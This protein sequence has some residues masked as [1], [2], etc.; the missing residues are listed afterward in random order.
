MAAAGGF[1][2]PVEQLI[3]AGVDVEAETYITWKGIVRH[4]RSALMRASE[5]GH[6]KVVKMLLAAGANMVASL[7]HPEDMPAQLFYP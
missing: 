2:R 5:G 6:T 1:Q 3:R 7:Y 4:G